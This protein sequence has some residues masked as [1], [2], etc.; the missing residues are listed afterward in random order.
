M[1]KVLAI[2]CIVI[3]S[4]MVLA[5]PSSWQQHPMP[6]GDYAYLIGQLTAAVLMIG[7]LFF[8]VRWYLTLSGH[9]YKVSGQAW[10]SIFLGY[11]F[12]GL[13]V[14]ALLLRVNPMFGVFM[15]ALWALIGFSCWKWRRKIRSTER[16]LSSSSSSS[17]NAVT[18]G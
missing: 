4:L 6:S 10:A 12:I 11:S 16:S 5:I 8:S 2:I 18:A 15:L 7:F 17:L 13:V 9:T 14:G 3:F 1:K